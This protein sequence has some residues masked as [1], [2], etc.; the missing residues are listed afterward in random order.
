MAIKLSKNLEGSSSVKFSNVVKLNSP[1]AQFPKGYSFPVGKLVK[2][3]AFEY[4]KE[5][6]GEKVSTVRLQF[7]YKEVGQNKKGSLIISE[8]APDT[9]S[10]KYEVNLDRLNKR[11]MHIFEV[12]IGKDKFSNDIEA[13][14][15]DDYFRAVADE[16]N[17][18]VY[19][20]NDKKRK[21]YARYP[22]YI[23]ILYGMGNNSNRQQLPM[24]PNFVERA[25]NEKEAYVPCS[26]D[27]SNRDIISAPEATTP[28]MGM[29]AMGGAMNNSFSA[30]SEDDFPDELG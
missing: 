27:V 20:A 30:G 23:K 6:M 7:T 14:T 4:E 11:I 3:E 18:H 22:L 2:V 15:F 1:S 16:F 8:F 21:E 29:G 17:K 5:V 24:F 13:E 19:I 9:T 10:D 28:T 12:T 25:T 26:L